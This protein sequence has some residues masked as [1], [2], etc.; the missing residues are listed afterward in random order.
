MYLGRSRLFRQE[1]VADIDDPVACR[2]RS[3]RP[4][5]RSFS[6]AF[7]SATYRETPAYVAAIDTFSSAVIVGTRS[8][9]WNTKPTPSR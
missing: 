5:M 1:P 4:T 8:K 6:T 7:R 3:P 9:P 2:M